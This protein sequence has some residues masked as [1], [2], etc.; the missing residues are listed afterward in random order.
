MRNFGRKSFF[1]LERTLEHTLRLPKGDYLQAAQQT[2]G[3]TSRRQFE[4][5]KGVKKRF[6]QNAGFS[7]E[8]PAL[9]TGQHVWRIRCWS[10]SGPSSPGSSPGSGALIA[11]EDRSANDE[12]G[13]SGR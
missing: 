11:L 13:T 7:A 9:A 4:M 10:S 12:D 5:R 2:F 6:K 3:R 1:A 8:A